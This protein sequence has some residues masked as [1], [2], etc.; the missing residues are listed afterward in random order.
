MNWNYG[1]TP[2]L[3]KEVE[4]L[5]KNGTTKKDMMIKGKYGNYEWRNYTDSAVLGWR[6]I[7]EN[8]T[9]TKENKTMNDFIAMLKKIKPNVDFENEDAL[10][11]DGILESLDI[12]TI[13]A[14]IADKYDVIIPSDEITSDNFNSA[15]ALY[16]LVEDLK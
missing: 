2:E 16:E 5:L 12:I 1:N 7:T 15:E 13:I 8:K 4:I 9:N 6:E 3:Y 14:E 11:D 10:V